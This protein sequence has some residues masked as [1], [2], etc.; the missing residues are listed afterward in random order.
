MALQSIYKLQIQH[1]STDG[2]TY[3]LFEELSIFL[4][5]S[6]ITADHTS[7]HI[8]LGPQLRT[9][10]ARVC[11]MKMT[12]TNSWHT[13][14]IHTH[15]HINQTRCAR[16]HWFMHSSYMMDGLHIFAAPTTNMGM[17][18]AIA[19]GTR[20]SF[21]IKK[22]THRSVP[23]NLRLPHRAGLCGGKCTHTQ[24]LIASWRLVGKSCDALRQAHQ[25][26]GKQLVRCC[27]V[28]IITVQSTDVLAVVAWRRRWVCLSV[29]TIHIYRV[30]PANESEHGA[31]A[32]TRS[33]PLFNCHLDMRP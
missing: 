3:T 9:I 24:K 16:S 14:S 25:H 26:S 7:F 23:Y 17:I 2:Q 31:R 22:K 5:R 29:D 19:D 27:E 18:C 11:L 15:I 1:K 21:L 13:A 8:W 33:E 30:R 28:A 20:K 32:R 6:V 12:N 4:N 10:Y